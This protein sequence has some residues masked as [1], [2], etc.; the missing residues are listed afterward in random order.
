MINQESIEYG[1][2]SDEL[3]FIKSKLM[4]VENAILDEINNHIQ[5]KKEHDDIQGWYAILKDSIQDL[6]IVSKALEPYDLI[7][8]K[9]AI[10]S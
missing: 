10:S 8:E 5:L 1:V 2:F 4:I 6:K 3:N 9:A 7:N